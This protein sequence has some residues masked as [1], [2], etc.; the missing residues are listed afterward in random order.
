MNIFRSVVGAL[1]LLGAASSCVAQ[2]SPWFVGVNTGYS[3]LD[4]DVYNLSSG[5]KLD[6]L[7]DSN[8]PSVGVEFGFRFSRYLALCGELHDYGSGFQGVFPDGDSPRAPGDGDYTQSLYPYE[9]RIR[10]AS[11]QIM[12]ILPIS[13]SF[14][15]FA[16]VGILYSD[17]R[18]SWTERRGHTETVSASD[19]LLG[20]G[21]EY[22]FSKRWSVRLE[23]EHAQLGLGTLQGGLYWHF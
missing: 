20:V 2:E 18:Y 21:A 19:L 17:L 14:R 22:G 5:R 15:L 11:V 7:K 16:K 4:H 10:G 12:P 6:R 3:W 8:G 9:V 1:I 13:D 23:Y